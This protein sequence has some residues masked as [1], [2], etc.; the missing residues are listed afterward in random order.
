MMSSFLPIIDRLPFKGAFLFVTEIIY[1]ESGTKSK[2]MHCYQKDN[3]IIQ[4]HFS[5]QVIAGSIITEQICQTAFLLLPLEQVK[6]SKVVLQK[7]TSNY[8]RPI[9][10]EQKVFAEA[11][12]VYQDGHSFI[13]KGA[14]YVESLTCVTIKAGAQIFI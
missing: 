13:F 14:A 8:L 10:P 12:I 9:L 7:V 3:N 5:G 4:G 2:T 1:L 11:E 6:G